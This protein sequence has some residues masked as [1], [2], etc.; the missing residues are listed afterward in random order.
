MLRQGSQDRPQLG[1]GT[2]AV[3]NSHQS[4]GIGTPKVAAGTLSVMGSLGP[5]P[6]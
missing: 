2:K 3:R 4:R 5:W 1:T 6:C